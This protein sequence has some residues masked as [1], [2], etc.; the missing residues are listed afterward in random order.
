[1]EADNADSQRQQVN[2]NMQ[3]RQLDPNMQKQQRLAELE[4]TQMMQQQ[5]QQHRQQMEQQQ[6]KKVK[7]NNSGVS[8]ILNKFNNIIQNS[9][10]K[11]KDVVVV[12]ILFIVLNLD[13]VNNI[14]IKHIPFISTEGVLNINGVI[15]KSV[16][17]GIIFFIIST[18]LV[19]L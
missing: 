12:V 3:D 15:G 1:M 2:D 6:Q 4:R 8:G 18:L 13:I 17:A 19:V 11:L 9:Q 14:L 10:A 16:I 7:K 5:Y